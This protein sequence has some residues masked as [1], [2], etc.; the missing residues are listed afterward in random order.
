MI[1]PLAPA[2]LMALAAFQLSALLLFLDPRL[3]AAP[4]LVGSASTCPS[5]AAAGRAC[6]GWP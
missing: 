3:A 1:L 6:P 4:L 2:H 5:S